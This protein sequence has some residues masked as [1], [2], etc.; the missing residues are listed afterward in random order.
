MKLWRN[1][2]AVLLALTAI[3]SGMTTALANTAIPDGM[4]AE[5]HYL[6]QI[7]KRYHLP[8]EV[9]NP[10]DRYGTGDPTIL[11]IDASTGIFTPIADGS[12][13]ITA[14]CGNQ[15]RYFQVTV[16]T[17]QPATSAQ[18]QTL[19]QRINALALHPVPAEQIT[20]PYMQ[21]YYNRYTGLISDHMS[22]YE[23]LWAVY[24]YIVQ[25]YRENTLRESGNLP[26]FFQ[27]TSYAH[28]LC[29]ALHIVGFDVKY[30]S[31]K[32]AAKGG[33]WTNHAWCAITVGDDLVY[34][35]ANIPAEHGGNPHYYF[36][37]L[38][39]SGIYRDDEVNRISYSDDMMTTSVQF[40]Q[41]VSAVPAP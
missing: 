8:E 41:K 7:G 9:K 29:R 39:G 12:T 20:S 17:A 36:C 24:D 13:F 40:E 3:A 16:S 35:D 27:C 28:E 31:G 23:K 38:P 6:A 22:N 34:L 25:H 5:K 14:T 32:C 21:R 30:M 10:G 37:T 18:P 19:E 2:I 15:T 4:Q 26:G 1:S 11:T 33:G